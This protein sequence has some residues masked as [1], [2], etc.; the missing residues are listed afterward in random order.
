MLREIF[1]GSENKELVSHQELVDAEPREVFII[2][3]LLIPI[4]GIGLYPKI[5][6]QVY[7]ASTSALVATVR[8]GVSQ[9]PAV[10]ARLS[11]PES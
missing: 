6:T 10:S 11:H 4:V 8:Q 9:L 5:I 7:D 1:Y 2:A 3:C